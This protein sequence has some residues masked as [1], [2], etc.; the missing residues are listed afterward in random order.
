MVYQSHCSILASFGASGNENSIDLKNSFIILSDLPIFTPFIFA[1]LAKIGW[2]EKYEKK[3]G[4]N[5]P[6]DKKK[7]AEICLCI[8]RL[9]VLFY[10][11]WGRVLCGG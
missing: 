11:T 2:G 10:S 1:K 7:Q 8:M 9:P 3:K 6:K 5:G 4:T